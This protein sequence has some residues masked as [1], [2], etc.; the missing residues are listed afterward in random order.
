MME[1][2]IILS[3][4]LRR[5]NILPSRKLTDHQDLKLLAELVLRPK[6]GLSVI[7]QTRNMNT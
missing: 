3:S 7:V 1:E 4:I 6:C 2:K 5:F